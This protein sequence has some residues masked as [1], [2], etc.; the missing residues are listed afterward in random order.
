MWTYWIN[1]TGVEEFSVDSQQKSVQTRFLWDSASPA[2]LP[3]MQIIA[4]GDSL[5]WVL[6]GN[7]VL[8]YNHQ[9]NTTLTIPLNQGKQQVFTS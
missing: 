9:K 8:K 6:T 2:A 1:E 7:A 5:V 3:I 4:Q